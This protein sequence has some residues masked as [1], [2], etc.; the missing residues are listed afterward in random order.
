MNDINPIKN[1]LS[2][3]Y[4]IPNYVWYFLLFLFFLLLLAFYF[5]FK[6]KKQF[7]KEEEQKEFIVDYEKCRKEARNKFSLLNKGNVKKY[8]FNLSVILKE[9]F[10]CYYQKDF[11]YCTTSEL[12]EN[13][14]LKSIKNFLKDI[15]FNLDVV[16]FSREDERIL[17][18]EKIE[19]LFNKIVK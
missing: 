9:Y 1:P 3:E 6:N 19:S 10:S 11:T 17:H 4:Q 15:F 12:L 18:F 14:D 16:K 8:S 5:Y 13:S 2:F 7:V